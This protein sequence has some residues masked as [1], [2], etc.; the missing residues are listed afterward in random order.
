MD[1]HHLIVEISV[2]G[3][4]TTASPTFTAGTSQGYVAATET[5]GVVFDPLFEVTPLLTLTKHK[6]DFRSTT[7]PF[8]MGFDTVTVEERP[9]TAIVRVKVDPTAAPER[10]AEEL[11]KR[12]GVVGV[13]ADVAI[14]PCIVCPGSA[15]LGTDRDLERLLDTT[16][17]KRCGMDGSGVTVAIVDTGVNMA[18]LNSKGKTP[19]FDAMRSWVPR[20]GLTPGAMPVGHGTMCAY[21]VCVAAPGCTLL[22]IALLSSTAPGGTRMDG[23]LSDAVRAYSH[24]V[25][26]LRGPARPGENRSL[27]VNNSWGMFHPSWD[28][29]VGHPGNYSDN[30][31]HPFNRIVSTLA[32]AGADIL[33]A[34][35]NCGS[36][37][38]D[39]RCQG[40]TNA[41]YGANSHPDVITVGGVDTTKQRVGYSTKGPGRLSANKPDLCGYTHFTGSGVYAADGGTSAATPVVAGVVAALR[42]KRPLD[43]TRPVSLPAAVKA[44][45]VSTAEDRGAAGF[46]LEYGAGIVNGSA[47]VRSACP[48][49]APV[50]ICRRYPWL[51][52]P[53][54]HICDR[55]PWLCSPRPFPPIPRL[56]PGPFPQSPLLGATS[57]AVVAQQLSIES[58][59]TDG[60]ELDAVEAYWLGV[61]AARLG[62]SSHLATPQPAE[63][64]RKCS[65]IGDGP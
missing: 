17:M 16:A 30:P 50:D 38:P 49:V 31:N 33:F 60:S 56:P 29:P 19:R 58:F 2:E 8:A 40:V 10:V 18:Y 48:T 35:G 61:A 34:A 20:A 45:L 37:C 62:S 53:P 59:G 44:L 41:I 26:L 63:S 12:A 39:G 43:P 65:C 11:A 25:N 22:D 55:F 24:L 46:D 47:I 6:A 42:T 36:D 9:K 23:L 32:A 28:F 21:D 52:P 13:F 1:E 27:V 64:T 54:S 57:A 4:P 14:E 7:R 3:E 5:P 15:A 51:C